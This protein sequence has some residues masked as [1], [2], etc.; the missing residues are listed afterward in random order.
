MCFEHDVSGLGVE[1]TRP[2]SAI[3]DDADMQMMTTSC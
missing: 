2:Q 3:F 1:A